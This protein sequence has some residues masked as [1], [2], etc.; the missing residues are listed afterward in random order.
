MSLLRALLVWIVIA[1]L[2]ALAAQLLMSG[3]PGYV[4]VRRGGVDYTTTVINA[5]AMLLGAMVVVWLLVTLILLPFRSWGRYRE[6][7]AQSRVGEGLDA[8]HQ[9]H[10]ARAEKLLAQSADENPHY[11]PAAR[12]AATQAAIGRGD[13]AGARAHLDKFGDRHPATRAIALAELALLDE[14]PI[15]ALTALDTPAAQPLPPRGLALRADAWAMTGHAAEAYG[16]LGALRRQ[17]ALPE[18]QLELREIRWAAASLHEAADANVLAER[19]EALPK[20]IRTET[21][22][23]LAYADRAVAL[24]WNHAALKSLETSLDARWDE[25]V[26]ARYASLEVGDPAHRQSR[27]ERWLNAHPSSPGVMLGLARLHHMQRDWPNSRDYLQRAIDQGAGSDAWVQMG[28]AYAAEGDDRNARLCY[29]NA[30]R[31]ARN[32]PVV[33]LPPATPLAAHD[34][35]IEPETRDAHGLPYVHGDAAPH[36]TDRF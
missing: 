33:A 26:A 21:P 14:R 35:L 3:D 25:R 27:M 2:G 31:A 36:P 30:L 32:E 24:G 11:E 5:I 19:W 15:D 9:G 8:L 1:L 10:Y 23:V 29:A 7:K 34:D 28:D 22:V 17:N 20:H 13:D 6:T 16:L 4:L 12:I 18:A